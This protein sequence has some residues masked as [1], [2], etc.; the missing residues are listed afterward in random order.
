MGSN[1]GRY[2][3]S[4][5]LKVSKSVMRVAYNTLHAWDRAIGLGF[6]E[7]AHNY[8]VRRAAAAYDMVDAPD[9]IYYARHYGDFIEEKLNSNGLKS[10]ARLL[11]LACGQGR[12]ISELVGRDL[13]FK[14]IMGVDFSDEVLSRAR[15]NLYGLSTDADIKLESSDLLDYVRSVEDKSVDVLL[16]LE[17]LYMLPNP[18][19]VL[20][21]ISR[22]LTSTGM[23]FF[24]VRT[25]YYYGLSAL[26]QGLFNKLQEFEVATADELFNSGVLLNW[27]SSERIFNDFAAS[28]GLVIQGCTAIGSCSGIPGDPLESIVRPSELSS[29]DQNSLLKLE[30]FMGDKYPD[31]GRYLLFSAV[32][33]KLHKDIQ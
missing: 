14:N 2:F 1:H 21:E 11:D 6:D 19:L 9:E 8:L 24:S 4:R 23:A 17:V 25:D 3:I 13:N 29:V 12:M 20:S 22:T 31:S 32:K 28:Y 5:L 30:K 16:L 27:T 26:K 7:G 15:K 33:A 10:Q 18:E